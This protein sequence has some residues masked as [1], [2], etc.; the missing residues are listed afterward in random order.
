MGHPTVPSLWSNPTSY[1]A[2]KSI[3]RKTAP[4]SAEVRDVSL[5]VFFGPVTRGVHPL[6]Q[7][8]R[9]R[10]SRR[11]SRGRPPSRRADRHGDRG[12]VTADR[13]AHRGL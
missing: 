11:R 2:R 10:R 1:Q 3:R 7:R 13:V 12:F 6:H 5:H 4:S 8:R 9:R